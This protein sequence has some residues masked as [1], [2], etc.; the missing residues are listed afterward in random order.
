ML[1]KWIK[2]LLSPPMMGDDENANVAFFL[3]AITLWGTPILLLFVIV[4]IL[5]G[6]NLVDAT[7]VFIGIVI[8]A[9]IASRFVLHFGYVRV[10]SRVLIFFAWLGVT[11]LAWVGNGLQDVALTAYITL[12]LSS[13]LL[14]GELDTL[15]LFLLSIAA[16]WGFAYADANGLHPAG[17]SKGVY[18]LARDMTLNYSLSTIAVYYMIRALRKSFT[19]GQ[20]EI[21]E[22]KKDTSVLKQ[23][24]AYLSALHETTLGIINRLEL[25]PLL[26]TILTHA[27]ELVNVHNALIELVTPDGSALQLELGI[28]LPTPYIGHL[29]YKNEGLTGRVWASGKTQIVNDYSNWEHR[30]R[31]VFND[32]K[33]IIGLPLMFDNEVIGV[34]A[35]LCV[36]NEREFVP[37]QVSLL[38]RFTALASLAIQNARLYEDV[39]NELR[40]RRSIQTALLENEEKFRKVFHSSPIAICITTLEDGRLL[41]A[42][43][44]YWDLMGLNEDALGKTSDELKLW[45]TPEERDKFVKTLTA[46]GSYYNPDD[47]FEDEDGKLKRVISFYEIIHIR[48]EKRILSMFYDMSLL[49]QTTD[50]LKDSE[51]RMRALLETIPDMIL[52]ITRDGLVT[53]MIPPKGMEDFM[54]VGQL[55]GRHLREAFSDVATL[56]ALSAVK[57]AIASDQ[58]KVFEFEEDMGGD[59]KTLEAR[60]IASAPDTALMMVRDVTQRKW[61]EMER[62]QFIN[63]LETKNRESETLR[64]STAI[65]ASSLEIPET[66]Q[67]ILE[68]VKRVV[69][70]DSASVWLYQDDKAFMVGSNGLPPGAEL[71]GTYVLS[72]REPD[73]AFWKDKVPYILLD[74][75]QD[76][77]P[78]F[79][80]PPKNYIRGW[81]T[82]P[83]RARGKLTGFIS[84]DS[85]TSGKFTEH[86]AEL[87]LTF[88]DQVSIALENARLFSDLQVEL[89]QR[90]LLIAELERRNKE[91]ET[92]QESTAIVAATL[93]KKIAVDRILDQLKHVVPYDSASVQLI[94]DD[95]LEIVGGVGLPLG[96]DELGTTFK[97][98]KGEP[99]ALVLSNEQPYVLFDN[100][101]QEAPSFGTAS[102]KS[103]HSWLA[104]PLKVK[105]NIIGIIA[106][107]G[108][109][110]SQFTER[111]ARLAV[112]YANQVAIA[113]ENARLFSDLQSEL[114]IRQD[115]ISELESKN[116]ELER[117]TYT[118]SHDLKSPLFTIRG[119]LGYLERDA[120]AGN[121]ERMKSDMQRI[122]DATDKMQQLLNELLEL[123]RIGRMKND[124]ESVPFEELAREA[125][126]LVQGRIMER[127]VAI[128]IEENMPVVYG[129]RQRLLEVVQNLVDNA[130]KFMG[131]QA[132]PHIDIGQNGYEDGM[133]IFYVR[134]NGIGI[135][136]EHHERIFGLFNKLD[137]KGDGTGIG[138]TLVKRIVE[139]HGG[140]IWVESEA[141]MGSTFSF[142]LPPEDEK[143]TN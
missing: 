12:I 49:R 79:R 81:L 120:L 119:F 92:L 115:L 63:E 111:H 27:C 129:D 32:I 3:H 18:A 107:D 103:I 100:I 47:S 37:D 77:Y 51:A 19:R 74:D 123:S 138:L 54:Q 126:G 84:L 50:A 40:E 23:Q 82:I 60:V 102:H 116:A 97:I 20:I 117:F 131:D 112:T 128:R 75:I 11:Y 90:V 96:E 85:R 78:D 6:E 25:R 127:G 72:D 52:E 94:K 65:V 66:V 135:P 118:V 2:G 71:P 70:Y 29:T 38:E 139:V 64:E 39:Q 45:P 140:R 68:Q 114:A 130:S 133:P 28:G 136:Q 30:D 1:R 31:D 121:H 13:G 61:V 76:E 17:T 109:Q 62:E 105:E 132:S 93:E 88:A 42:N 53:N 106:L 58:M 14:L 142:T 44:A 89:E 36:D 99:A 57:D 80:K 69:E 122:T 8:L 101:H 55:I 15:M 43:Y 41:E 16:I 9:F 83:M 26:E 95:L 108:N 48:D 56:Q 67:R 46:R 5:S 87:A 59:T 137:V 98:D 35:L 113:L 7:N 134:D 141:G 124:P 91:A 21:K 10:T 22:Y 33:G 4:R 73:H 110:P 104:V 125:V 34:L 143:S 86:D 24:A